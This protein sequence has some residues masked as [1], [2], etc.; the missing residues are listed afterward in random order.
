MALDGH[1]LS[2]QEQRD[3]TERIERLITNPSEQE[4]L[5]QT[6]KKDAEQCSVFFK[7]IPDAFIFSYEGREGDLTKLSFKPNPNFR[8]PSRQATVFR[9]M[10]GEMWVHNEQKR[11]ASLRG[12]LIADVKFGGGFLGYLR[13]GGTFD[14][15]QRELAPGQWDIAQLDVNMQGK[16]LF[17]KTIAVRQRQLR[18]EFRPVPRSLTLAEAAEMLTMEVIICPSHDLI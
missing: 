9:E 15:E 12:H 13:K 11:L 8:P 18:S 5:E 1:P 4:R 16:A 7:M 6:R 10:E 17:F 14:V 3:E 2:T